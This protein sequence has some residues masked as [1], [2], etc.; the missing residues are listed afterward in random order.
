MTKEYAAQIGRLK[1]VTAVATLDRGTGRVSMLVSGD[2]VLPLGGT[3][4]IQQTSYATLEQFKG[5]L[6]NGS[7]TGGSP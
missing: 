5:D 3:V 1:H 4:T 6:R 7:A 2:V